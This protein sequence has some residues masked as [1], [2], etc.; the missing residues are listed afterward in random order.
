MVI[1][2]GGMSDSNRRTDL[3]GT[4]GARRAR[5]RVSA[6]H[7]TSIYASQLQTNVPI[8]SILSAGDS[9]SASAPSSTPSSLHTARPRI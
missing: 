8:T 3:K 1:V 7:I 6:Q 2:G 5:H 9:R 4:E